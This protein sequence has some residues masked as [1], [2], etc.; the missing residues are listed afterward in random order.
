MQISL[1][2]CEGSLHRLPTAWCDH[3]NVSAILGLQFKRDVTSALNRANFLGKLSSFRTEP[4]ASLNQLILVAFSKV[5]KSMFVS[6]LSFIFFGDRSFSF[7]R[8]ES[9]V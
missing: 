1:V 9:I 6:L 4:V 2:D 3:F 7:L 5:Q 8:C